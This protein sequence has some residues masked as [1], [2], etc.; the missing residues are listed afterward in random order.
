MLRLAL[1]VLLV[2]AAAFAQDSHPAAIGKPHLCARHDYP[3]AA[4]AMGV[5]GATKL[6]FHI[7]PDGT[8]KDIAVQQSS[9]N[10]YLDQ[11]SL[12]CAATWTYRPAMQNGQP[13]EV[14]SWIGGLSMARRRMS[15]MRPNSC[16]LTT[17]RI[18]RATRRTPPSPGPSCSPMASMSTARWST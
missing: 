11:A 9:G 12:D 16:G 2:P 4:K 8:V 7:E 18:A 3:A 10:I 5:E 15:A 1:A 17:A 6:F 13:V 14:L